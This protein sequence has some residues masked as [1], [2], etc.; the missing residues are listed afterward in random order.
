MSLRLSLLSLQVTYRR[1]AQDR[2]RQYNA[3]ALC[4]SLQY[5]RHEEETNVDALSEIIIQCGE[6]LSGKS[7]EY[8][9]ARLAAHDFRNA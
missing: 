6:T 1:F 7:N 3:D 5:D 9:V 2:I 4:N 8:S